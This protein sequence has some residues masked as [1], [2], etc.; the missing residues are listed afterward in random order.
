M[1]GSTEQAGSGATAEQ[2]VEPHR[3]ALKIAAAVGV[4]ALATTGIAACSPD[5]G[6]SASTTSSGS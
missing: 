2:R 3:R 1:S 4:I 5:S 6:G